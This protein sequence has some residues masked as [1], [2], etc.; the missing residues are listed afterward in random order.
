[1]QHVSV[2]FSFFFLLG[3]KKRK[4]RPS[5]PWNKKAALEVYASEI[6]R[7]MHAFLPHSEGRSIR[8]LFY[9]LLLF[10]FDLEEIHQ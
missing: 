9:N 10:C 6:T 1:M 5:W 2:F 8:V 4:G 7:Y 3:G